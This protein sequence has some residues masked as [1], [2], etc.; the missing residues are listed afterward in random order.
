[1]SIIDGAYFW[2]HQSVFFMPCSTLL[3]PQN[4]NIMKRGSITTIKNFLKRFTI[5]M[6][7]HVPLNLRPWHNMDRHRSPSTW[8]YYI[9]M[10]LW[11]ALLIKLRWSQFNNSMHVNLRNSSC[12]N[13][14][15]SFT[16][17]MFLRFARF[18]RKRMK[19]WNK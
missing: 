8:F 3:F 7:P 5:Y 12:N 2:I 10:M 13:T 9:P 4:S 14:L 1:M 15:S 17:L 16:P 11:T 18:Q 6:G 19:K